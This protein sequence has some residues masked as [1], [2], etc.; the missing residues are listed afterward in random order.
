[1]KKV[2]TQF[3][4]L[5]DEIRSN[6]FADDSMVIVSPIDEHN[7]QTSPV[8]EP[9]DAYLI[10][11]IC[12]DYLCQIRETSD[13]KDDF[14]QLYQ[15]ASAGDAER[16]AEAQ[17]FQESYLPE[18]AVSWLMKHCFFQQMLGMPFQHVNTTTMLICRF[19]IRDIRNQFEREKC[20]K[21]L[22]VYRGQS[23]PD[24]M[25]E[26]WKNAEGKIIAHK[27]F[28]STTTDRDI[29]LIYIAEQ[30]EYKRVL[31]EIDADPDIQ[32]VKSFING[33][34]SSDLS[35]E[36]E[37]LFMIGS[38]FKIQEIRVDENGI[39]IIKM[40][41]CTMEKKNEIL[42][43]L[44]DLNEEKDSIG[45]AHL[46]F[47]LGRLLSYPQIL[48]HVNAI[49]QKCLADLTD[50]HP[51]R[52][53]CYDLLASTAMAIDDFDSCITWCDKSLEMKKKIFASND[54]KF[55]HSY[56]LL[57]HACSKKND[58]TRQLDALKQLLSILRQNLGDQHSDLV[59]YYVQIIAIYQSEQQFTEVLLCYHQ[60][61]IIMLK[62][63]PIDDVRLT[64]VY[65]NIGNTWASLSQY[66]LALGYY[67]TTLNIKLK[68]SL[69]TSDSIASTY[70]SIAFAYKEIGDIDQARIHFQKAMDIYRQ[71]GS[72]ADGIVLEIQQSIESLSS[73][74]S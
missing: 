65:N 6:Y 3:S 69:S 5:R 33:N 36:G 60:V 43:Q 49:I 25:F 21:K 47:Q 64:S 71:L 17:I 24:E 28:F 23:M 4:E 35:N 12:M 61:Y 73:T 50:D 42:S 48:H 46:Q 32:G 16:M 55:V 44:K 9:D 34:W 7:Q 59:Q 29:A 27:S 38:L 18:R 56:D 39:N 13:E 37:V 30:N 45:F 19:L 1:M 70:R 22:R 67:Q 68:D 57:V 52:I 31:F 11:D 10:S 72:S 40:S 58:T 51:N 54:P 62:Y 8:L 41:L 74:L 15:M 63:F 14:I 53:R 26:L 2:V 66:H 20:T